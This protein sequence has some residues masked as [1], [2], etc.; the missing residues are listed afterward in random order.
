MTLPPLTTFYS[1]A[2]STIAFSPEAFAYNVAVMRSVAERPVMAVVKAD[3]FGLGAVR[4]AKA[5]ISG[6]AEEIGV[7]TCAEAIELRQAG[8]TVPVLAWLLHPGAPIEPALRAGIRL[9]IASVSTFEEVAA[10]AQQLGV[11][12]TIEVE[13][14]TGMNRSGCVESTWNELFAAIAAS[15]SVRLLG[16]WTHLAGSRPEDFDPALSRLSDAVSR[17]RGFS[18]TPRQHAASSVPATV[19]PRTRLDIVRLGASLYGIEPDASLHLDLRTVARWH[20]RVSQ[21]RMVGVTDH[22]S[23]GRHALPAASKLALIPVGYAD[24]L[25]R[26]L[27]P[28]G[29]P[30]LRVCIRGER[31]PLVGTVSMDQTIINVG[32]SDVAVGDEV[33]L[34]GDPRH[35]EPDL[36]EWA[37]LLGSIPQEVLT[38]VGRRVDRVDH[39]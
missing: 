19:D 18:L 36:Q 4:I 38:G 10:I 31:F 6:G 24:G 37:T 30:S 8:I 14:E 15:R 33:T 29:G 7:A 2:P 13:V 32:Q 16:V 5:A 25:P 20:T 23:Y 21:L 27:S 3:G 26:R 28:A 17:A 11:R 22:I 12:A 34:L 9:S 35:G 1:A 39:T